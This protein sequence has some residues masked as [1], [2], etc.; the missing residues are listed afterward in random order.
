M[1]EDQRYQGSTYKENPR[2]KN[3]K[4]K[5]VE[6]PAE[7]PEE[8]MLQQPYVEDVEDLDDEYESLDDDLSDDNSPTDAL[9]EAPTPP[10]AVTEEHLNVFDFLVNNTPTASQA[11]NDE[12]SLVR[13]DHDQDAYI[14]PDGVMIQDE[15]DDVQY[16]TGPVPSQRP[17]VTPAATKPKKKTRDG[18]VKK[19]KKR[20]RLHVETG[21][22][23][24]TDAP[25]V[26]HSGLTGGLTRL[27]RPV[28]PPSPDYS[29]GDAAET[30]ASPTKKS[31]HSKRRTE[32]IGNNLL[33]LVSGKTKPKKRKVHKKKTHTSRRHSDPKTGKLI[34][35]RPGSGDSANPHNQMILFAPPADL[36]LS[37]ITKGPESERGCS[38]NKALKR[39]H[40]E[41][42]AS[43]G[44]KS[45]NSEE[46]DLFR[47]LRM[48][49]NDRGEIVLFSLE[50]EE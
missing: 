29:G 8:K 45:K 46:K 10:P 31:R 26:L 35:F 24:M 49:R 22:T 44:S 33:A 9:P 43:G 3:K 6:E 20:K 17:L 16:G 48:R 34:Q 15:D 42:N 40:R 7:V 41:R 32:T 13:Y 25:P 12:T 4:V 2:N 23:A 28:F 11:M 5:I 39:F 21:D 1:T 19:D 30:P 36:F 37:M 47:S 14:G 18:E 27:M 38:V 50:D